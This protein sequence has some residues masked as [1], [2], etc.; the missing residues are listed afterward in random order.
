MPKQTF[1]NLPEEKRARIVD[2]ALTEFAEK[3]YTGA[4]IT[5]IV[6]AAGIAKGSFYQYFEDKD[7]LYA[8]IFSASLVIRT[9]PCWT[10]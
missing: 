6:A 8:H 9:F 10:I 2:V 1:L 7:D 4:S 3:G 5:G